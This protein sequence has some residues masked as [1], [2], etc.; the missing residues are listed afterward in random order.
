MQNLRL[1][2]FNL[3]FEQNIRNNYEGSGDTVT[4]L[5]NTNKAKKRNRKAA[6]IIDHKGTA[7]K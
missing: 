3:Q 4:I 1:D 7:N 6:F 2:H 5:N